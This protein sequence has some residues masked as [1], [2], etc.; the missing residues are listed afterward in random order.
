M[1]FQPLYDIDPVR[2]RAQLLAHR[3]NPEAPLGP[4]LQRLMNRLRWDP[5]GE[6]LVVVARP[7]GQEWVIG[8]LSKS[9]VIGKVTGRPPA[10]SKRAALGT[11]RGTRMTRSCG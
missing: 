3:A 6:H 5:P 11:G 1:D 4:D 2:D 7:G 8:Q 10:I 9:G